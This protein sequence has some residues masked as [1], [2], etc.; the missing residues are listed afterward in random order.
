MNSY[1]GALAVLP[2]SDV[3]AG[4]AFTIAGNVFANGI[5]RWN[6][7]AWAPLGAGVTGTATGA[8]ASVN[9]L[10]VLPNGDLVAA[11]RFT[12]AGGVS[13]NNIARWD[14]TAWFPL[15][16]GL[17]PAP[18]PFQYAWAQAVA[19]LPNGDVLA[20]GTFATG[21]GVVARWDGTQWSSLGT[22]WYTRVNTI[23]VLPNGD[24]LAG[25]DNGSYGYNIARWNGVSWA[26]LGAGTTGSPFWVS[27]LSELPNG[28]VVAA[29]SFSVVGGVLAA[30]IARW[31]GA[32]WSAMAV[33]HSIPDS[34]ISAAAFLPNGDLVAGGYFRFVGAALANG[35]ARRVG[36][37]W[38]PMGTG[39]PNYGVAAVVVLPNGDVI[40]GG[41]FTSAG[42]VPAN[43]IAR[44][45]GVVWS[46]LGVG[47]TGGV[48]RL[49]VSRNGDLIA[50]N[51]SGIWRWDGLAWTQISVAVGVA[52]VTELANGDLVAAGHLLAGGGVAVARWTGTTWVPWVP[53]YWSAVN[54]MVELPNGD[55]LLSGSWASSGTNVNSLVARWNGVN[56][57]IEGLPTLTN[58]STAPVNAMT[59]LPDGSVLAAGSFSAINGVP[60]ASIARWD[61]LQWSAVGA[62]LTGSINGST[63]AASNAA[64]MVRAPNGDVVLVGNF[65]SAGT[66]VS[67]LTA[68]LTTTCPATAVSFGVGC[69]GAGGANVLTAKSL[70]WVGSTYTAEATG[71]SQSACA[72]CPRRRSRCPRSCRKACPAARCSLLPAERMSMCRSPAAS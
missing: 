19:C 27:S 21:G 18:G 47:V 62:G 17:Q 67:L 59:V 39:M 53:G 26:N 7:S 23:L 72:A 36:V 65:T 42:G 4:G 63:S 25:G 66:Q 33:D 15:G 40:A 31:D 1:I 58:S 32:A 60:A 64:A 24:V 48:S 10:T 71:L 8:G 38:V 16:T 11:G 51:A 46:P 69:T 30:N 43:N 29:G 3:V 41:T 68:R 14:G 37:N 61:G 55:L 5:A 9:S 57:W 54:A 12:T 56:W 34:G 22:G 52:V 13:A 49:F 2:N 45:T 35:I 20:G 50:S 44:W 28:D 6:G 70:P